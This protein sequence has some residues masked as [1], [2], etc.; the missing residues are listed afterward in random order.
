MSV[1]RESEL[2]LLEPSVPP[3]DPRWQDR[4]VWRRVVVAA[5]SAAFARLAAEEWAKADQATGTGGGVGNESPSA[6]AGFGDEKLYRVRR[7]PWTG[8]EAAPTAEG[9]G[10]VVA[11][12]PFPPGTEPDTLE[13]VT[14]R[15]LGRDRP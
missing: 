10:H 15:R 13:S 4:T 1:V 14:A 8:E 5:P 3:G 11:A 12:E 7:L 2:W 6:L 9:I